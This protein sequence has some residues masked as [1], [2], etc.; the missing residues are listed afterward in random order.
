MEPRCT[1][2]VGLGTSTSSSFLTTATLT[3]ERPTGS[4]LTSSNG[5]SIIVNPEQY[6]WQ[7]EMVTP[8]SNELV[9]YELHA[10][11]FGTSEGGP[12]PG[13]FPGVRAH[14]DHVQ[15]LGINA[16]ELLPIN[17]F[18]GDQSWGYNPGHIFSVESY[19]GGPQQLKQTDR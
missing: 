9:I 7:H 6:Q 3:G 4:Q 1:R 5:K 15:D 8:N 14:L 10:G 2:R 11:T 19:Y 17:E 18:A 16:I 13:N 12:F